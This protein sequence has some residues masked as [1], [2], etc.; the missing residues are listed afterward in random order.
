MGQCQAKSQVGL[1][2]PKIQV[3]YEFL[4]TDKLAINEENL[5]IGSLLP[6]SFHLMSISYSG[7]E[8]FTFP[9]DLTTG[10]HPQ[11]NGHHLRATQF[12]VVPR[13]TVG[14]ERNGMNYSCFLTTNI[15]APP[16]SVAFGRKDKI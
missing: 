12:S 3:S 9:E 4:R 16:S 1:S 5:K 7:L 8:T 2:D 13:V 6:D 14:N 15:T 10:P 11:G